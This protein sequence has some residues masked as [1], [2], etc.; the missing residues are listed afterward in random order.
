MLHKLIHNFLELMLRV[1]VIVGLSEV[2]IFLKLL[3]IHFCEWLF[4]IFLCVH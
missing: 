3:N 2:K 1:L 4:S